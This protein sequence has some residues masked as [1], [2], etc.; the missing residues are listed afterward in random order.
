MGEQ[1]KIQVDTIR[2]KHKQKQS[3]LEDQLAHNQESRENERLKFRTKINELMTQ[4]E[5]LR[6]HLSVGKNAHKREITALKAHLTRGE[7]SESERRAGQS[8]NTSQE[9]EPADDMKL[10]IEMLHLQ[11]SEAKEKNVH[12][13]QR[14]KEA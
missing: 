3:M 1:A 2:R 4:V 11:L 5:S 12:A 9:R 13:N 7:L 8:Q 14:L 6:K 10:K